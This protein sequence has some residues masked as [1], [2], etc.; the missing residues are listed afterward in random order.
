LR[1]H[2]QQYAKD[3]GLDFPNLPDP[4]PFEVIGV[5]SVDLSPFGSA[6]FTGGFRPNY[7]SWLPWPE[8]FDEVG[9]PLQTEGASTAR[10]GLYFVG[11]HFMRTRKSAL[12][13]GVGDDARV[14]ATQVANL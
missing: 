11:L 13:C 3:N 7:R 12:L 1:D 10:R 6:I 4:E 5:E 9:F 8:A 14:V 2:F